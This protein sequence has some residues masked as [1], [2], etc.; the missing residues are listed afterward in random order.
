[1]NEVEDAVIVEQ[2]DQVKQQ[3]L[4]EALAE[5]LNI[6]E[7]KLKNFETLLDMYIAEKVGTF[8]NTED[9]LMILAAGVQRA[10]STAIMELRELRKN[11]DRV[12]PVFIH[13]EKLD[14]IRVT[15]T[16]G[17]VEGI[18]LEVYR[19]GQ[20]V[21]YV[22]AENLLNGYKTFAWKHY[23]GEVGTVGYI[24]IPSA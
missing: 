9:N 6:P 23:N 22:E 18:T 2:E 13:D 21:E 3:T 20:W 17:T 14:G 4:F 19:E 24:W 1:M 8:L 11:L 5:M 12:K 10:G 15:F 7:E 16:S